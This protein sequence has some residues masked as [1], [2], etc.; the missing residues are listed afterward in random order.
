[1]YSEGMGTIND[2]VHSEKEKS[3]IELP[4]IKIP[5]FNGNSTKWRSFIQ[6]FDK[7]VHCNQHISNSIKMQYLK[8]SLKAEAAKLVSHIAPTA[9]NYE[10]CY[11]I[12]KNRY[13]NKRELLG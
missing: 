5:E 7:I 10:S 13:D 11:A 12:L 8:T 2:I 4:K 6:L 9:E 3:N 1:M